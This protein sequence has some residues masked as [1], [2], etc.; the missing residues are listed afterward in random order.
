MLTLETIR[1]RRQRMNIIKTVI[2]FLEGTDDSMRIDAVRKRVNTDDLRYV[3][4]AD[5][6][7]EM[8]D[9][10]MRLRGDFHKS[11]KKASEDVKTSRTKQN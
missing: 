3:T 6:R 9:D 2:D 1:I 4:I 11:I 10:M 7:R 5:S 8:R